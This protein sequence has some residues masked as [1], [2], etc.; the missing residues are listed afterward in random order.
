MAQDADVLVIGGGV[1][2]LCSAH[3]LAERGR[4]VTVVERRRVGAGASEG[5]AGIICPSESIPLS[6][7]GVIT[8]ALKWMF[9]GSSPF[10]IKPRLDPALIGW[11]WRFARSCNRSHVSRS[12]PLLCAL[13]TRSRELYEQ[14]A[15]RP[16]FDFG[17]HHKGLLKLAVT[18]QGLKECVNQVT[19]HR[20]AGMDAV[21]LDAVQVGDRLGGLTS[22]AIGGSFLA[23]DAHITPL[24]FVDNLAAD[25]QQRG[26]AIHGE[27]EVLGFE[28]SAG[29]I[30]SVRT[31]QGTFNVEA[32]VLAAGSWSPPFARELGLS[33]P[34]QPAKGYSVMVPR[35]KDHPEQPIQ[36]QEAKVIATPMGDR[37]RIAGTL[38]LAGMNEAI[39]H[40]RVQAIL[41]ATARFLPSL[42]IGRLPILQVWR[43]LRPCTPDGLPFLGHLPNLDNA[44]VAAGHAMIGMS[45]GPV[46]GELVGQ[47]LDGQAPQTDIHL[48]RPNRFA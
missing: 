17:Y 14:F 45:L 3:F 30:S 22:P 39:N 20:E 29:R 2:G 42:D 18:T 27:T 26:M 1:V 11:L 32:V 16:G 8:K 31:T 21:A 13:H 48:L 38:E 36:L 25:L 44:I 7:P 19:I 9:D 46:T 6:A 34:I 10:Y 37:L 5:N 40:R 23:D 43:G 28:R 47:L 4:H 15:A 35:P 24:A 12:V 33:L 41:N